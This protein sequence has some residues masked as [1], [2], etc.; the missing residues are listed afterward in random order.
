MNLELQNY[1]QKNGK[2]ALLPYR[3]GKIARQ[4]SDND[5]HSFSIKTVVTIWTGLNRK[6]YKCHATVTVISDTVSTLP[7]VDLDIFFIYWHEVNS[8]A[9]QVS[10]FSQFQNK[11]Y[12]TYLYSGISSLQQRAAH[13]C[14]AATTH[15]GDQL[16]SICGHSLALESFFFLFLQSPSI[17][18]WQNWW[19]H[20][21]PCWKFY[22]W[23][24][25]VLLK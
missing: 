21:H 23:W 1:F 6:L 7:L 12:E 4:G 11:I 22:F 13:V 5:L 19:Y 9:E 25:F 16:L 14:S 15:D 8:I 20:C 18:Y 2:C 17:T 24:E 10:S 3:S